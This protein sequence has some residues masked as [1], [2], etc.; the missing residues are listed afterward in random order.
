MTYAPGPVK[1]HSMR[2]RARSFRVHFAACIAIAASV[3]GAAHATCPAANRYAY[4]FG[5]AT[6]G[7]L[8]YASSY[9]YTGTSTALGNQNFTVSWPVVNGTSSTVVAGLQMPRIDP[10]INDGLPT[11]ANNLIVGMIL[12]GRTADITSGTRVIVTRFTFATPIRTFSVQL[13]DIDFASNAFRDWLHISGS[14]GAA[15]YTPAI[16][17]PVGSNNT[18]GPR[19]AVGSTIALGSATTPFV[20]T[21]REAIG[22]GSAPN[23]DDTGT[24][25]A[26]FTQPVTQVEIRYGN[27]GVSAGGTATG[28]QAFGIQRVS[29][30]PM[31]VLAIAKA[32]NPATSV[33]T[34]PNRFNIPNADVDYTLT[35]TNTGGSPVD[36]NATILRDILPANVTFFNGD[37]DTVT[38]GT[39]NFIFNAGTSGLTFAPANLSYSNNGGASYAYTPA[40]GY[41]PA[42]TAIQLNPQGSMAANSSFTIRFRTRIK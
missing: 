6:A 34:D 39:Q 4:E 15:V 25:T 21:D 33:L 13:N 1:R 24:L 7:T 29:W 36:L 9:T 18:T 10:I 32:S 26:T 31:P 5:T 8:N 23:T 12:G 37:I 41:D 17:T 14:N 30:C 2:W 38:A 16:S 42:V 22:T 11:T 3:S 27:N 40:A 35:V 19:T 20:Q 28:Q